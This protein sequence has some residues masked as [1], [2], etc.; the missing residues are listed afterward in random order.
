MILINDF[1]QYVPMS[2]TFIYYLIHSYIFKIFRITSL[3]I[4]QT[5]SHRL[6][7]GDVLTYKLITLI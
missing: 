2:Y 5:Y 3:F 7:A 1:V 4:S 6:A